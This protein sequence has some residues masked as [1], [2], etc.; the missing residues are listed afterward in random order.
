MKIQKNPVYE[1]SF[2]NI[3]S[4]PE[5]AKR[6]GT[7]LFRNSRTK[8][9][10]VMGICEYE[11]VIKG[12]FGNAVV[13]VEGKKDKETDTWSITNQVV[14]FKDTNE[15]YLLYENGK[16]MFVEEVDEDINGEIPKMNLPIRI[17]DI[18]ER[19]VYY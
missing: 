1:Q 19:E 13:K 5:L 18:P 7:P 9:G 16:K 8:G 4:H 12:P 2:V 11:Y 10:D 15:A 17:E 6:L 14:E 3:G